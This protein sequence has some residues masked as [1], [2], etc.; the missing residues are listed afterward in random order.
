MTST[1]KHLDKTR[2][3]ALSIAAAAFAATLIG[4]GA[5]AEWTSSAQ[6][7]QT[8]SSGQVKI[9]FPA[10][11]GANEFATAASNIAPGD[12]VARKV[13]LN[14]TGS[15]DLS[16]VTLAS[17]ATGLTTLFTDPNGLQLT[18]QRC[19]LAAGWSGAGTG[20]YTC[21]S[22][23]ISSVYSGAANI[24]T[25]ASLSNLTVNTAGTKDSLLFTLSLPTTAPDT[26][27][28]Q[29][30]SITWTLVGTQR[31]GTSK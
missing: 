17:S 8:V 15:I 21:P 27:K 4:V 23:T 6:Q 16:G 5:Y 10:A 19:S 3:V 24:S 22:G 11:G 30:G 2:K 20:P 31:T 12:T 28:N 9:E 13:D 1:S 25:P 14:N 7:S 18:V 29:S 26:L